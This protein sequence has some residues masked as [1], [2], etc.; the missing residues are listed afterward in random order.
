MSRPRL[1]VPSTWG[2]LGPS[3]ALPTS[4]VLGLKGVQNRDTSAVMPTIASTMMPNRPVPIDHRRVN[5]SARVFV[6]FSLTV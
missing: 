5:H 1:S 6:V 2:Q 4:T 3:Q